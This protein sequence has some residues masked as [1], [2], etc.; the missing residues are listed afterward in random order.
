MTEETGSIH[1]VCRE[2]PT[3]FLKIPLKSTEQ[4]Y[5]IFLIPTLL[6]CIL[7]VVNFSA[8][9]VVAIQHFREGN[10]I[11]GCCTIAV[12]YLP[13]LV[14]FILTV[15]RPDWWMTDDDKVTKGAFAWF[16]LQLCHLIAFPLFALY[17]YAGL[18][19][20][21]VD[22]IML[23]GIERKKTLN[24]AA[25]PAAMELYFFLQAWFQ[26][27]PQAVLQTH[28][29]FRER[30][31]AR[32]QQSETVQILCIL[33][34]IGVMAM[35]TMSFQRYESQRVNGRK[36][37]WALWL[38]KY[39]I[40]ELNSFEEKAPLHAASPS[41]VTKELNPSIA[42]NSTQSND[43]N[44][45]RRSE[46]RVVLERQISTTPPLPPKNAPLIPP[47]TPLRRITSFTPIPVPDM[48]AP[49]R[50]DSLVQESSESTVM[51]AQELDEK[52]S[53]RLST[54]IIPKRIQSTKGLDEDDA[55]G[56]CV[57]CLWWFLFILPRVI[58]IAIFFESFPFYL[59]GFLSLHYALMLAYLFYYAKYQ[60]ATTIF[61]NLWLGLVYIFSMI[62]YR[63]KFKYADKWIASYCTFVML[64]NAALTIV[65]FYYGE[66]T[67]FW[68]T[69]A[70]SL[71]F[72]S[73]GLCISSSVV[74][75][76]LLKPGKRRV[77]AS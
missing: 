74:Y 17:R 50:P 48:P 41:S 39:R 47:P 71:T 49:P 12:I 54:L 42:E 1:S 36:L 66:W 22:A 60:D 9:L 64:Q 61:V 58:S 34:S 31:I 16:A 27:A 7:Y 2:K 75:H 53:E 76:T 25:A 14:Y 19:V 18:I 77:Y 6:S 37:P 23:S 46:S 13:A 24:L 69:Y 32:S 45:N 10:P 3:H 62:E 70:F 8:D 52:P 73:M 15:T 72:I 57:S 33:V 5:L 40:Q 56:K 29:L 38:K 44:S 20:L 63:I 11:W 68:Y 30:A 67:G 51:R 65:W 28:L 43:E 26:A 21:I 59:L 55:V 35:K 4:I